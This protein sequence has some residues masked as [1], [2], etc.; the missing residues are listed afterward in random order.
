MMSLWVWSLCVC[1]PQVLPTADGRSQTYG[2]G[3]MLDQLSAQ[4]SQFIG[5]VIGE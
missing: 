2:G 5:K 4:V 1:V 3:N